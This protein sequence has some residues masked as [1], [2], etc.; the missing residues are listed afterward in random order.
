MLVF[1]AVL[2]LCLPV[3]KVKGPVYVKYITKDFKMSLT[4]L[5]SDE[6]VH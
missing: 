5:L 6:F 2:V 1:T 4:D 3:T